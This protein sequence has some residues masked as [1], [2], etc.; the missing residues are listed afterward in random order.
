MLLWQLLWLLRFVNITVTLQY[1]SICLVPELCR[2]WP[3]IF[4]RGNATN[5]SKFRKKVNKFL[6][7]NVGGAQEF[8]YCVT[9][10]N[11]TPSARAHTPRHTLKR[12]RFFSFVSNRWRRSFCCRRCLHVVKTRWVRDAC[13]DRHLATGKGSYSALFGVYKSFTSY[14]N[15]KNNAL[16]QRKD[17]IIW[18]CLYHGAQF[19]TSTRYRAYLE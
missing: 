14:G 4:G 19:Y 16:L 10:N 5:R 13:L 8:R 3:K 1:T 15:D 17:S 6:R 9:V 18:H 11:K 12:L 2:D 7:R